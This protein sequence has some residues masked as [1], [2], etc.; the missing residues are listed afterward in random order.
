MSNK[1][2]VFWLTLVDFLI[3][4]IFFG[5]FAFV[6]VKTIEYVAIAEGPGA[7]GGTNPD[8]NSINWGAQTILSKY[9]KD[10]GFK[11]LQELTD[12]LT[13]L[14]PADRFKELLERE[15]KKS[16]PDVAPNSSTGDPGDSKPGLRTIPCLTTPDG[17]AKAVARLKLYKDLI[18]FT[19]ETSDLRAMLTK[20]N[21]TYDQV[22]SL[23]PDEFKKIF[24]ALR[25][26]GSASTCANYIDI[27]M[28][29]VQLHYMV[30][31]MF[32][33]KS[34]QNKADR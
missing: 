34:L 32:N 15:K 21:V 7:P 12:Q 11:N 27:D 17:K 23:K 10:A 18:V 20:L 25:Q 9:A 2:T 19:E 3:Q 28:Y 22:E 16:P 31:R 29:D 5:L 4:V 26:Q 30:T 33:E 1:E 13:K 6:A 14:V 8:P 24:S